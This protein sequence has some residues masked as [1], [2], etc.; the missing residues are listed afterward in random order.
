MSNA[1]QLFNLMTG[2]EITG[3][4]T[5][6]MWRSLMG[7]GTVEEFLEFMRTGIAGKSAYQTWLDLGN[8][9][10]EEDFVNSLKA[11]VNQIQADYAQTD[12]TASDY[13]KNKLK[14]AITHYSD[15]TNV[16]KS[17]KSFMISVDLDNLP[18]ESQ[19]IY[20]PETVLQ[21]YFNIISGGSAISRA[22]YFTG[23][24][25]TLT[26]DFAQSNPNLIQIM[27]SNASGST[28]YQYN[29]NDNTWESNDSIIGANSINYSFVPRSSFP[30]TAN[31][32]QI[33]TIDSI[34]KDDT[35]LKQIQLNVIDN[36]FKTN[37]LEVAITSTNTD[38]DTTLTCDT[39]FTDIWNAFE[40]GRNVIVNLFG[41]DFVQAEF[42]KITT[43][44]SEIKSVHFSQLSGEIL[45]E[46]VLNEDESI[47]KT[48]T[49]FA[50]KEYIKDAIV[51][52][53][54]IQIPSYYAELEMTSGIMKQVD[55]KTLTPEILYIADSS[56]IFSVGLV[57]ICDDNSVFNILAYTR[58]ALFYILND[59]T[60]K[61]LK[62]YSLDKTSWNN[63]V[64]EVNYS[65]TSSKTTITKTLTR[66]AFY[67][68]IDNRTE[69][70]PTA[71]YHPATKKYVDESKV[72]IT[73][74]IILSD[75]NGYT[76]T[77]T[78]GNKYEFQVK[79]F[80]FINNIHDNTDGY[81][82][83]DSYIIYLNDETANGTTELIQI[84]KDIVEYLLSVNNFTVKFVYNGTILGIC[85]NCGIDPVD[86][87]NFVCGKN[88]VR[89]STNLGG[90]VSEPT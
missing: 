53:T 68:G 87:L 32:G 4:S 88:L 22:S 49:H 67:L 19:T 12:E 48:E 39:L 90:T 89:L 7:G 71:D 85:K 38:S 10:T 15:C 21:L 80:D 29:I 20:I 26:I 43:E 2:S 82:M 34:A 86:G 72:P 63:Q 6:D 42:N 65:D 16:Q 56:E 5:Y 69:Y 50:T 74:S 81:S 33:V 59:T 1:N 27:R 36:D 66:N 9:G 23:S 73:V 70:T 60:N 47:T 17:G 14:P 79:N 24:Y 45:T 84:Y 11:E 46:Y 58:P 52:N 76:G 64:Y 30:D 40:A 13:I 37:D 54:T 35:D 77:I 61:I 31:K 57:Y 28:I 75:A 44:N 62:I 55:V 41:T 78:I 18:A 83:M 25:S 3:E 8:E 51:Q